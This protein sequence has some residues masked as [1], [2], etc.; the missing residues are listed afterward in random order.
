M[1]IA[2]YGAGSLGTIMGAFLSESNPNVDLI[3]VNEA[4]VNELNNNGAHIVGK[5]DY[6]QNV[7]ALTPSQINDKYDIV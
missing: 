5:V 2:I 3:D 4:H 7:K 6:S 1:K